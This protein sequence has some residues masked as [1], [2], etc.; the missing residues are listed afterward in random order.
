M[1]DIAEVSAPAW[2]SCDAALSAPR[3]RA[4]I[5]EEPLDDEC[6]L[7]DERTAD[8]RRLNATTRLIWRGCDGDTT[9]R[10]IA[11]RLVAAFEVEFDQALAHVEQ[12]LAALAE[13]DLFEPGAPR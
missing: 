3:R 2:T 10:E 1:T 6:I 7:V 12:V 11:S 13:A 9:T 4:E 8:A 5:R